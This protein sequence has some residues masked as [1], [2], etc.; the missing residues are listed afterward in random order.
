MPNLKFFHFYEEFCLTINPKNINH[1]IFLSI[2]IPLF[3]LKVNPPPN[4]NSLI[5]LF[6]PE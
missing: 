6:H 3:H 2:I 4:Y 5:I 1:L